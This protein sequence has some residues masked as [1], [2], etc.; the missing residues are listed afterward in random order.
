MLANVCPKFAAIAYNSMP[1]KAAIVA[2]L[3]CCVKSAQYLVSLKGGVF[4]H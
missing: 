4:L 3:G 2:N 1:Y